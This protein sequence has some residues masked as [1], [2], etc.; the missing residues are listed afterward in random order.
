MTEILLISHGL[1]AEGIIDSMKMLIG[2]VENVENITFS[3]DMG[4]EELQEEVKQY[5]SKTKDKNIL[6]FTDLKGGTP[7]NVASILTHEKEEV[8]VFYG[9]NLP[10]VIEAVSLKDSLSFEELVQ[11]IENSV[12]DSI[13]FS[14]L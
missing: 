5:L 3:V 12:T 10:I 7:F 2:E 14:E 1:L 4:I 11:H 6:I 8:K 13:G 9:M